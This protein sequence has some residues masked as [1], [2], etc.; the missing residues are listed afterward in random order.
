MHTLQETHSGLEKKFQHE[1]QHDGQDD[2]ACDI[3]RCQDAQR[4]QTAEKEGL[5]I[6]R[7]RHLGFVGGLRRRSIWLRQMIVGDMGDKGGR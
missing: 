4:E 1:G 5:R 2:R 6:G 7:Q 3:E